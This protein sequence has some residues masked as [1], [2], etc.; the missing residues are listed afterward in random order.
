MKQLNRTNYT[1]A[2]QRC[3]KVMQFGEGNF[4]RAFVDWI[5]Q[6]CN[7]CGATNSNVVVVQP[8]P[9]GRVANLA[10]QDGLY[11]VCLEGIEN[12]VPTKSRQIVDVLQNFVNPYTQYDAFLQYARS[13]DLQVIVSNTTEAGIV[14]DKTDIDFSVCPKSFPGKLLAFLEERYKYF[15]GSY[16]SGLAIVPC[17]LIDNN[18]EKLL[19]TLEE[20]AQIR[21]MSAEFVDWLVNANHFT[22]T[23]VDRIVPGYPKDNAME[24]CDEIGFVDNNIVKGEI[25]HLWVLKKQLQVQRVFPVDKADLNVKYVDDIT[26]YKQRKVKILNGSHT[27]MVPIAYLCGLDTVGEAMADSDVSKFVET[28]MFDVVEPTVNLPQDELRQFA[29]DVLD[30]FRNPYIRHELMSIALNSTTKFVTRILPT[31]NDYLAKFGV[32][33]K[34][35]LFAFA[36]L[37]MF[38]K[39]QRGSDAIALND[40]AAYLDFWKQVW[41][42]ANS[43]DIAEYA[44][45]AE[46][47]WKQNL[48]SEQNVKIVA[49][50]LEDMQRKGMRAALQHFLENECK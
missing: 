36:A 34:H 32:A 12:G 31:Y 28:F 30:R 16:D 48:A 1:Q 39:G 45:N 14:L 29:E 17:E 24:I 8:M 42:R 35:V 27:S 25:F 15:A 38:Y 20:L 33:P 26:P 11:T 50:Y 43:C 47:V 5:L 10:E 7:D 18:G 9:L 40:D 23:L 2:K 13:K 49:E 22:S 3:V 41:S 46:W 37:T 44:L 21:K 19:Q 6:K 4:L